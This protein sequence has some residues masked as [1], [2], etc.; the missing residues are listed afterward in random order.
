MVELRPLIVVTGTIHIEGGET[1]TVRT[2]QRDQSGKR[3]KVT[4]DRNVSE[5]RRAA[6]VI[7]TDYMRRLRRIHIMRTP[8]GVLVDPLRL[9]DVKELWNTINRKIIAYNSTTRVCAI[10]NCVLWEKLH[11][12]RLAAVS[13]WIDA[14]V[15][16]NEETV[17]SVL[18]ALEFKPKATA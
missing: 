9:T 3:L 5:D 16:E 2:S 15:S 17:L 8:F 14:R 12:T 4:L 13:G 11:G 18:S 10:S 7:A 1:N 6:A